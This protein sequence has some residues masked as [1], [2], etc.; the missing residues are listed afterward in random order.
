M[1]KPYELG[2]RVRLS[3]LGKSRTLK[4]NDKRGRVVGFGSTDRIIRVKFEELQCPVSLH[5]S[6]LERDTRA[7][8][9]ARYGLANPL[10]E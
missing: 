8:L 1:T 5:R 9:E 10:S 3:E 4:G 6:Y 7:E 2:D